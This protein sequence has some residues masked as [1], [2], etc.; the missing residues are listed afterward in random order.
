MRTLCEQNGI[1]LILIKAPTNFWGYY[2]YDEW[3][4]QICEYARRNDVAYY[5][6]IPRAEEM[7]IDWQTDT[8]DEGLHLNAN[9]AEKFTEYFGKILA[10]KYGLDSRKDE[11]EIA[12]RWDA[13]LAEYQII[14]K[15]MEN[16]K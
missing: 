11:S 12:L 7:G 4:Q 3:D 8:Y 10:E 16:S 13:Y 15:E 2:W 5:N 1:Q 14:K 9:G 6:F